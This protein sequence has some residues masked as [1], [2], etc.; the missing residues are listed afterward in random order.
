MYIRFQNSCTYDLFDNYFEIKSDVFN[1]AYRFHGV[2]Y[3]QAKYLCQNLQ[4]GV[5][6]ELLLSEFESS[7]KKI[8]EIILFLKQNNMVIECD[9]L[10]FKS[11]EDTLYDRQIRFLDSFETN[12]FN[13]EVFNKNLQN[14]KVVIVGLGAYG[15]WLTLHCARLG[16]KNIVGIDHDVVELSNLHRQVLYS[17]DDVGLGK[18]LSCSKKLTEVDQTIKFHSVCKKIEDEFDL[19]PYLEGADLIFNAFGYY[20]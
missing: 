4:K 14:R 9:H 13:G 12:Q 3:E 17:K 2:A 15:T 6:K 18:A 10:V 1:K 5:L 20:H 11:P 16:I 7:L 19:V 8:N